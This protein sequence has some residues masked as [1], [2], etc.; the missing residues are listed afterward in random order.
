MYAL[1]TASYRKLYKCRFCPKADR[2]HRAIAHALKH[3]VQLDRV[4]FYCTLCNF[5]CTATVDLL[6]HVKQYKRHVEEVARNGIT[7]EQTVLRQSTYPVDPNSL[8]EVIDMETSADDQD[9]EEY[10]TTL[11]YQRP[12]VNHG[13]S[14]S[15]MSNVYVLPPTSSSITFTPTIYNEGTARNPTPHLISIPDPCTSQIS[16]Q[17]MPALSSIPV[18]NLTSPVPFTGVYNN[19]LKKTNTIPVSRQVIV[20]QQLSSAKDGFKS[21]LSKFKTSG[22]ARVFQPIP[23]QATTSS[24]SAFPCV[25]ISISNTAS[26]TSIPTS[27]AVQSKQQQLTPTSN[28]TENYQNLFQIATPLQDENILPDLLEYDLNVPLFSNNEE[29]VKNTNIEQKNKDNNN[30]NN[31]CELIDL[32]NVIKQSTLEV[33]NAI[34]K[35]NEVLSEENRGRQIQQHKETNRL[36]QSIFEELRSLNRQVAMQNRNHAWTRRAPSSLRTPSRSQDKRVKSVVKK[37]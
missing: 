4:P 13:Q 1:K 19:A 10:T 22:D 8:V 6:H 28:E 25:P 9:E 27:T 36:L 20:P 29:N 14:D 31:K 21:A 37:I 35:G 2:K 17:S 15:S 16:I 32:S 3:H 23:V 5:R 34:N 7:D 30:N 18:V 12:M 26:M 24:V 11:S 33:V